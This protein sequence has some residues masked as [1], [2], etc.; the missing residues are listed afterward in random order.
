[1]ADHRIDDV[2]GRTTVIETR[3]GGGAGMMIGVLV[4]I[5][6]VAA[7]AFFLFTQSQNDTK[8]TDAVV[9]ASQSI[10]DAAKD[11][12]KAITGAAD[13]VTPDKK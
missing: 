3:S 11:A 12:G 7:I 6:L 9:G 2:P 8:R 1:M 4:I 10:D 13:R 5:A